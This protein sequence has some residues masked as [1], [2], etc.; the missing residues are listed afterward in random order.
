MQGLIQHLQRNDIGDEG[1]IEIAE[2]LKVNRTLTI[3]HLQVRFINF[4][5]NHIGIKVLWK[6]KH[7]S[8]I[9][10]DMKEQ[11]ALRKH[12]RSTTH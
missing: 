7:H 1:A 2:A 8:T 12:W 6:I 5:T 11:L 4:C 9:K 10:L 3:L